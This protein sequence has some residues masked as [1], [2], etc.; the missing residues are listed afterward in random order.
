M[1][2]HKASPVYFLSFVLLNR[3]MNTAAR[4]IAYKNSRKINKD[5]QTVTSTKI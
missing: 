4:T 5:L 3:R 1:N 2:S